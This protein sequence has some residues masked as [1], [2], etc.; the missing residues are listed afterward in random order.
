MEKPIET[1]RLIK[2][3]SQ[4]Q[5]IEHAPIVCLFLCFVIEVLA[6]WLYLLRLPCKLSMVELVDTPFVL[7][8]KTF[9][10]LHFK[11]R[12]N[13]E[14]INFL[15]LWQIGWLN[16]KCFHVAV[17]GSSRFQVGRVWNAKVSKNN[18]RILRKTICGHPQIGKV[19]AQISSHFSY[20]LIVKQLQLL[21]TSWI[22]A[23]CF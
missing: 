18:V 7:N 4:H 6:S 14:W 12:R 20:V 3:S 15:M 11:D 8:F 10:G 9:Y 5:C 2:F 17:E 23:L 13:D 21:Y 22:H 1:C 19:W 16:L